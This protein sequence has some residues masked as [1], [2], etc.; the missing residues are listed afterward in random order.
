MKTNWFI[1]FVVAGVVA[2]TAFAYGLSELG[3]MDTL[4]RAPGRI[5]ECRALCEATNSPQWAYTTGNGCTCG[6]WSP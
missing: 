5:A 6:R 1:G 2:S 3:R 4:R